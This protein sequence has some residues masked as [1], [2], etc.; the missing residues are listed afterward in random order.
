MPAERVVSCRLIGS[1]GG[2]KEN[3]RVSYDNP[4]VSF[5]LVQV[6][7]CGANCARSYPIAAV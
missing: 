1:N 3:V 4:V 7:W 6:N 5:N 2:S